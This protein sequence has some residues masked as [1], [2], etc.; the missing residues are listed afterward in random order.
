VGGGKWV[1]RAFSPPHTQTGER[2]RREQAI[3]M[4]IRHTLTLPKERFD[5]ITNMRRFSCAGCRLF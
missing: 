1:F 4:E 3:M 5:C 2:R